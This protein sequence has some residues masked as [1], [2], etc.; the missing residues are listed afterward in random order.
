MVLLS[1]FRDI[2]GGEKIILDSSKRLNPYMLQLNEDHELKVIFLVRD[3]RSW[4]YALNLKNMGNLI[5]LPYKWA[6]YLIRIE[7]FLKKNN[8]NYFT[9]GYEEFALYPHL[10]FPL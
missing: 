1:V 7:T 10:I 6:N 3:F 4:S 8:I 2:Y 9:L 5:F